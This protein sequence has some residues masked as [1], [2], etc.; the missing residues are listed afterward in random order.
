[1]YSC[2]VS[3]WRK[4]P[5]GQSPLLTHV[6]RPTSS[7]TELLLSKCSKPCLSKPAISSWPLKMHAGLSFL[8]T[9][10]KKITK[11]FFNYSNTLVPIFFHPAPPVQPSP[12]TT[13]DPTPFWLCPWG[14]Y[15]CSL[16][17]LSLLSPIILLL[18]PLWLLSACSLVQCLWLC[19]AC[20]FVLIRFHL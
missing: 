5:W 16:M 14:L 12:P 19:F 6:S 18:P 10:F 3:V 9:F 15:T 8:Q 7:A 4:S 11:I 2:P 1:M 13:L 20:L 17:N